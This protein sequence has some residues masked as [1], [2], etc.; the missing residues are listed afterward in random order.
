MAT[1]RRLLVE[2]QP[3]FRTAVV[4]DARITAKL[5]GEHH[6]FRSRVEALAQIVRLA[7]VTDAFLAQICYRAR[8]ACRA[9]GIAVLPVLLHHAAIS[10]G[11]VSIGDHVVLR[12]GVYLPHGQVVI[13]GVTFVGEGVVLRPFVT[14]GLRDGHI[15]G[16]HLEERV[17]IGTGAKVFGP[18]R[19]GA[20]AQVGANAVVVDD[21]AE[22]VTVVGVPARPV[23]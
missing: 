10:T 2:Q 7:W 11:Q 16:P 19:V 21:V 4:A 5:R 14:L 3:G 6:Q 1:V 18:V 9:R 23:A 15:F 13:D 20:G 17:M 12:P 22:R 8:V